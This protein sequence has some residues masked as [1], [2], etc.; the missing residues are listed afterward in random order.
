MDTLSEILGGLRLTSGFFLEAEFTAPWCIDSAPDSEPVRKILPKAQHIAFY[1]LLIE[2]CCR[3]RLKDDSAVLDLTSGDLLM[4]PQSDR[5][6]MGSDLQVKAVLS[7]TL[8]QPA[9]R[10]DLFR[11]RH[12]G[13]GART[14]FVCGYLACDPRL[15]QPLLSAMPRMLRMPVGEGAAGE[16][17][18][19]TLRH[20]AAETRAGRPGAQA[21][22][23]KLSE[24]VMVEAIRAY[25]ERL[26]ENEKGWC[27]AVR[28]SF[29]SR[30]L[31]LMHA[32][33]A[34]PWTV[35]KLGREVGLSRSALADRFT[36]LLNVPPM[37]YLTRTRMALAA[38][39]LRESGDAVAHIAERVGY[40][41]EA[42]FNRAFK[43]AFGVPPASWR[44]RAGPDGSPAAEQH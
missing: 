42:A 1:H 38:R 40:D 29:V 26:P 8:V 25:I 20:G 14:R 7:D 18:I 30:A 9:R 43:K 4:L 22:L 32:R 36:E 5:H 17:L 3:A 35:D 2:G 16:W 11:I 23:A 44:R 21:V 12:G 31:A 39:D 33:P 41:S 10:G 28:D 24:L 6:L 19:E 27:A 34:Q 15:C 37:Q 13:D